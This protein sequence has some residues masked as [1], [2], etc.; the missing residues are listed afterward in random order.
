MQRNL[1]FVLWHLM[2][3]LHS[4]GTE[5]VFAIGNN[6]HA[7]FLCVHN[8]MTNMVFIHL[9]LIHVSY[10]HQTYQLRATHAA[11]HHVPVQTCD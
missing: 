3:V 7:F 5:W 1:L 2:Q 4:A 11:L 6:Q 8:F 10:V 9:M